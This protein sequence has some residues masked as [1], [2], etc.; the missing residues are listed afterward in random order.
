MAK[1]NSLSILERLDSLDNTKDL[2]Q[3]TR[4]FLDWEKVYASFG[5]QENKEL[6]VSIYDKYIN[7][8]SETN[9]QLLGL[10]FQKKF[11]GNTDNLQEILSAI[12]FLD[13]NWERLGKKITF[14][15]KKK[16]VLIYRFIKWFEDE[17]KIIIEDNKKEIRQKTEEEK[18]IQDKHKIQENKQDLIQT[19]QVVS[20]SYENSISKLAEKIKSQIS[21]KAPEFQDKIEKKV[22]AL[23]KQYSTLKE[24][25]AYLLV[26]LAYQKNNSDLQSKI[27]LSIQEK[28]FILKVEKKY[29]NILSEKL[30]WDERIQ[31]EINKFVQETTYNEIIE[32]SLDTENFTKETLDTKEQKFLS[33][34]YSKL[35]NIFLERVS[36]TS[37]KSNT[38]DLKNKYEKFLITGEVEDEDKLIFE[39]LWNLL[40]EKFIRETK[41]NYIQEYKKIAMKEYTKSIFS[42]IYETMWIA[43]LSKEQENKDN[44]SGVKKWFDIREK[45][46]IQ[47]NFRYED[48]PLS[49]DITPDGS[50]YMTNYLARKS[51]D[52]DGLD[53]KTSG[54][55]ELK[56]TKL[57]NFFSI[58]WLEDLLNP[59]KLDIRSLLDNQSSL[60]EIIKKNISLKLSQNNS[61]G[62][63]WLMKTEIEYE[64]QKQSLAHKLL[65]LYRPPVKRDYLE[66]NKW[67]IT[68][69]QR[70]LFSLLNRYDLTIRTNKKASLVLDSFFSN[71]NV[72]WLLTNLWKN[73]S[74]NEL[75]QKLRFTRLNGLDLS[76]IRNFT[77]KIATVNSEND[78]SKL[79]EIEWYKREYQN[80]KVKIVKEVSAD[81]ILERQLDEA[82][83][84]EKTHTNKR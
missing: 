35:V 80:N 24:D 41:W 55:F 52:P 82:Y 36:S 38:L 28:R 74:T 81:I 49:F 32:S 34:K 15:L 62:N 14:A 1:K 47:M 25:E 21:E 18:I 26:F 10:F 17:A 46:T 12:L 78:L 8:L 56:K 65:L 9:K 5:K 2:Q 57:N 33:K 54:I 69:Q 16:P 22:L 39:K 64:T 40:K 59:K 71:A 20:D 45:W 19:K 75:F 7:Q 48:T 6:F 42:M 63:R 13:K 4:D 70:G 3:E 84:Y 72:Q 58:V 53:T 50:M 43:G 83:R 76:Q 37:G 60:T 67:E 23:K 31:D 30:I 44:I 68:E 79:P 77:N 73:I 61:L 27:D 29:S 66:G 51:Q 11:F